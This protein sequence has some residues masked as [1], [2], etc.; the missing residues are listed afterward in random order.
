VAFLD[1]LDDL[2]VVKD[3]L[4]RSWQLGTVQV[5]YQLSQRFEL[6]YTGPDN[7]EHR[8]VVIHGAPFGS[9]ERFV[10]AVQNEVSGFGKEAV[11]V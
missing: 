6:S 7:A 10:N 5:D 8:P 2:F 9:T 4:G 11:S 1:G 3:V